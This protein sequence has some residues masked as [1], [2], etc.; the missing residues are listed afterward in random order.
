M[1]IFPLTPFNQ[2][3]LLIT[4]LAKWQLY[5]SARSSYGP[6]VDALASDSHYTSGPLDLESSRH[7][8]SLQTPLDAAFWHN[9]SEVFLTNDTAFSLYAN[10]T[11][12][13]APPPI[14]GRSCNEAC[15]NVTICDMR[16]MR[17]EDNC[18][19]GTIAS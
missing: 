1:C 14:G 9:L 18:V 19:C 13:D 6:L 8:P 5:Y 16:A 3:H 17:G 7:S 10:R 2:P 11:T 12:R 15:R 4:S